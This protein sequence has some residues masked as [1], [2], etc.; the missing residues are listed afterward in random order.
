MDSQAKGNLFPRLIKEIRARKSLS[1]AKFGNLL[2]PPVT[3][4]SVGQWERGENAP[5]RKYWPKIAALAEMEL[6]QFYEYVE[7]G[8]TSQSSLLEEIVQKIKSL[9]PKDLEIVA[10]LTAEKWAESGEVRPKANKQHLALLRRGTADWN[11]WREKNPDIRPELYGVDLSG[12]HDFDLN[13]VNLS[14]TDLR[15]AQLQHVKFIKAD[16]EGADLSGANLSGA[17]LEGADL[18][19]AN[20]SHANL[21]SSHLLSANL[22]WANLSWA[23]LRDANLNEANFREANLSN[24]DLTFADLRWAI[25]VET[26]LERATLVQCSVYGASIWHPKLDEAKELEL[27]TSVHGGWV[28]NEN[29]VYVDDL[30][31]APILHKI[32]NTPLLYKTLRQRF[33][34][35]KEAIRYA[36]ELVNDYGVDV[37]DGSRLYFDMKNRWCQVHQTGNSL[38]ITAFD[39]RKRSLLLKV[40]D[41]KIIS[42]LRPG[43]L[44]N[45]KALVESEI[46][47]KEV[48]EQNV[49]ETGKTAKIRE[50]PVG[51]T[52]VD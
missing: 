35:E 34:E 12:I 18:R 52:C 2:A 13:G 51:E 37:P 33:E 48:A 22:R 7:T 30:E 36:Q 27:N 21:N 49:Y 43:D 8:L 31:L 16:L 15:E 29:A 50:F 26:N 25:L 9:A 10:Q 41:G 44:D 39:T 23:E 11:K 38:Y 3:A 14:W 6:G 47:K 20:L 42:Y 45:L 32:Y 1:Q 46:G 17:N 28:N 24:A 40:I 4:Q 5:A 19:H